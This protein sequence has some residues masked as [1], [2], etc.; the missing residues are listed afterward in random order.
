LN[1]G[2]TSTAERIAAPKIDFEKYT[3]ANGL[4]VILSENHRLPI[5]AVNIWYH[6]GP[7]N[8]RP[9]SQPFVKSQN[10]RSTGSGLPGDFRDPP[11]IR[12][13]PLQV[14]SAS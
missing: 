14:M 4:E 1:D 13:Q 6:V 12:T 9:P 11:R 2:W 3:L 8:E 10:R 7:A 5:V